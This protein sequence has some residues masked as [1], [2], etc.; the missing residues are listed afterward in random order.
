MSREMTADEFKQQ[1]NSP[2]ELALYEYLYSAIN[3]NSKAMG[4]LKLQ[5]LLFRAQQEA[6][7]QINVEAAREERKEERLRKMMRRMKQIAPP[8]NNPSE[9]DE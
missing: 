7:K 5:E 6:N 8:E 2:M 9:G 4:L 3:P 1:C